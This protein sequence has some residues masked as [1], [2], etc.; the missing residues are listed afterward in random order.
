VSVRDPAST[1]RL[2][3]LAC[4]LGS[5]IATLDGSVVNVALP[6]IQRS[7]GGGLAGQQWV[8]NSYLL[9]LGSLILIGGSLGDLYGERRRRLRR[10]LA[11]VRART[12]DR[13][14]DRCSRA[15]GRRQRAADARF[16]CRDRA[17]VL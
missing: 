3:L 5:G 12:Y 9:T 14:A 15:G 16:A 2:T 4:I 11:A 1:K 8:L 7:L 13:R 6:T 10:R 17:H